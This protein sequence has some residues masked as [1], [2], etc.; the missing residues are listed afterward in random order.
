VCHQ[1]AVQIHN[2]VLWNGRLAFA[3]VL[4]IVVLELCRGRTG[5]VDYYQ[6]AT[7]DEGIE[8][9]DN[10]TTGGTFPPAVVRTL[11]DIHPR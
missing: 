5:G 2:G 7:N 4:W 11:F 1:V 9:N 10:G 3:V 6:E 8:N